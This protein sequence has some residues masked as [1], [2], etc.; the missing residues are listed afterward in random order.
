MAP[1]TLLQSSKW[2]VEESAVVLEPVE[3]AARAPAAGGSG[4]RG[5]PG[6]R[7]RGNAQ[8]RPAVF[9]TIDKVNGDV[10]TLTTSQGSATVNISTST[11]VMV[12]KQGTAD[13]LRAGARV[14]VTGDKQADGSINGNSIQVVAGQGAS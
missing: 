10:L 1:S 14:M 12:Q 3:A 13:D 7:P 11:K 5:T 2:A 8:G 9:G 6:A 4:P